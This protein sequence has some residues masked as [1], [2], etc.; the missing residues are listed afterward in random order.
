MEVSSWVTPA[1][2]SRLRGDRMTEPQSSLT[3]R[4]PPALTTVNSFWFLLNSSWP[5]VIGLVATG[6]ITSALGNEN[7]SRSSNPDEAHDAKRRASNSERGRQ[8]SPGV[9]AGMPSPEDRELSRR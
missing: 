5:V 7:A 6:L 9:V 2:F 1:L 3:V 8:L 4:V